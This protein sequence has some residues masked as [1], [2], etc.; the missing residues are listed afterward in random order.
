MINNVALD[1]VIGLVF[2]YLLYS[3]LATVLS[4]IIATALG[5]RARNLKETIN[6]MLTDEADEE[7]SFLSRL[8]DSFKLM[9]NPQNDV[10][11]NFYDH[12][13]I[14]YLGSSGIFRIPSSFK[15]ISFS[16]TLI[17]VI[18]NNKPATREELDEKLKEIIMFGKRRTAKQASQD[19]QPTQD[20]SVK[21][22]RDTAIYIRTLWQD[23]YGDI[24][25]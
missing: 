14:K 19:N 18:L 17:N 10:V 24:E 15:A 1:V 13:E 5:L 6:R 7:K 21:L 16:K 3:L 2:I 11:N 23:S 20:D 12:P 8:W 22:D 25:K 9:K 4:E